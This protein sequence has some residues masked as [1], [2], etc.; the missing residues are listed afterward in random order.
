[1]THRLTFIFLFLS[2]HLFANDTTKVLFIGNSFTGSHNMPAIFDNLAKGAGHHV[3]IVSHAPGGVYVGD[4]RPGPLSHA[5]DPVVYNLIRSDKWDY[6]VI[7][8]NQGF[9]SHGIGVFPPYSM[10]VEGHQAL[11][12]SAVANN[13]CTKVVLFAGWCFKNGWPPDFSNGS[14]MNQRV[15]V[16]YNFIN[17]TLDEIVSPIG[18]A[19]NRMIKKQ[20]A[21]DLWDTDEAH[22]S[23]AG[24][25]LTAATIYSTIFRSS[26]EKVNYKGNLD[27]ATAR[28][29]RKTAFETVIDSL[30]P[31]FLAKHTVPL[32]MNGTQ[33]SSATGYKKYDWYNDNV[34]MGSTATPS[35]SPVTTGHCYQVVVTGNDDCQQRSATSCSHPASIGG[36]D[37]KGNELNIYPN[38]ATDAFYIS[39]SEPSAISVAIY[40][41]TGSRVYTGK[42]E[43]P[44]GNI[45]K[46]QVPAL[47]PGAYM[48]QVQTAT[49]LY[50]A[51]LAIEGR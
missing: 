38:P 21:T 34:L 6:L 10:V 43:I 33:L 26:A 41:L 7:Q 22:P 15:Y 40:N 45:C 17:K 44:M 4:I 11:R 18:I 2:L 32:T 39:L 19:W 49:G 20:P 31:T 42:H 16:N 24:S 12:D 13:P 25:Y 1:M 37:R 35:Y 29:M 14:D 36:Q 9:Y 23:Y 47:S 46:I 3:K 5:Y 8:D 48:V 30:V 51:R 50:T 28:L 27:S